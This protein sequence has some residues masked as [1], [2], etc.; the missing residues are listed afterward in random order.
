MA[1][2]NIRWTVELVERIQTLIIENQH[3]APME[4]IRTVLRNDLNLSPR[5]SAILG[6][7]RAGND[8]DLLDGFLAGGYDGRAT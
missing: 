7:V 6:G 2:G 8:L 4:L 1:R 5:V 3:T